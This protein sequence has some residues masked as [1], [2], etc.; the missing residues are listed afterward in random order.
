MPTEIRLYQFSQSY[1]NTPMLDFYCILYCRCQALIGLR[2]YEEEFRPYL[3]NNEA[4]KI[5][6]YGGEGEGIIVNILSRV[7]NIPVNVIYYSRATYF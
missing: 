1:Q 2:K 5:L 6:E 4:E 3:L 7:L